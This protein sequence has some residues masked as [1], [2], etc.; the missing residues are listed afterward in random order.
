MTL[1][2]SFFRNVDEEFGT[3]TGKLTKTLLLFLALN[4]V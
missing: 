4:Q 3:Q 2:I 1:T